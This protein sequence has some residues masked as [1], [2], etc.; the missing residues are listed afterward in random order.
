MAV[1]A[2]LGLARGAGGV[3]NLGQ[4]VWRRSAM[5]VAAGRS[6]RQQLIEAVQAFGGR[7]CAQPL[8][9]GQWL[10]FGLDGGDQRSARTI[11]QT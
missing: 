1:Q 7:S 8:H 11:H 10:W 4:S 2:A 9:V 6:L 5:F 3:E